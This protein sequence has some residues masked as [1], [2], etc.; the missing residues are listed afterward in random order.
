[1]KKYKTPKEA[2]TY[3][4]ELLENP[5]KLQSYISWDVKKFAKTKM[6]KS[7]SYDWKCNLCHA[8]VGPWKSNPKKRACD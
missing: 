2:A 7:C 3:I 5:I 1:M 6:G 4:L 8:A